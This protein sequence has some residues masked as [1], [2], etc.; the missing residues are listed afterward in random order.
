MYTIGEALIDFIPSVTD[1][2]L[3][4]VPSFK[5][6]MGGAPANVAI[7]VSKCGGTSAFI[8][9]LG[10]DAFGEHI[11]EQLKLHKVNTDYLFRTKEANTGLAF[12]SLMKDGQR[13][14]SFYRKP[15][16]DMLLTDE[17]VKH[18]DFQAGDLLHFCSVDLIEAPV[19]YAHIH[20]INKAINKDTIIS[21]DP[22][23]RLPLWESEQACR[24]TIQ[25]FIPKADILKVSDDELA[26]IT[27]IAD[28]KEALA[29]LF[30]GRVKWVIYTKGKDGAMV[31]TKDTQ[32]AHPGYK[33]EALDT[34]GAGDAF[35]GSFLYQVVSLKSDLAK[36]NDE[37]FE[38]MLQFS[39]AYAA[40]TT[41]KHGAVDALPT[42]EEVNVFIKEHE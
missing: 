27:S 25:A 20:A 16:A 5:R 15:S 37:K 40:L 18:V 39:N 36:V 31:I 2:E 9:K 4:D 34:T 42:V 33:V 35:I 19:K 6:M 1:S 32:A 24:E 38:E 22:N 29:S 26:F 17:E 8:S 10:I 41:M 30:Q 28:E 3:K 21:F 23:V 12:V 7:S 11:I 13:D 14:F